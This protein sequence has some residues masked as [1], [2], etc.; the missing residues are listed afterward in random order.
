MATEPQ[1]SVWLF[2]PAASADENGLVAAGADITPST[3]LTA[4]R[5]GLFPM[6]L[7]EEGIIGWWSPDPRGVL[8]LN[9]LHI[10][11]SLEKSFQ[12]FEIRVDT[13]FEEVIISCADPNRS[14][15]WI[16][17]QI[18]SAY[19]DLHDLG[20]AHSIEAWDE[21]GLAGG[22]YGVSVGGL[23]AGESM[24]HRKSDASKVA[25]V[26]LVNLMNDGESRLIDVQW[27]TDH[28]QTL[29]CSEKRRETYLE[30]VKNLTIKTSPNW[31][32]E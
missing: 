11:K 25:L 14:K 10:S 7:Q 17:N 4:Y 27:L 28:L 29:G 2:P 19:I 1:E 12:N 5:N 26:G 30:E 31:A 15:G 23:F 13:A 21:D 8:R 32:V 3:L 6:P 16:D 20:W 9:D 22:L 18:I 24:F